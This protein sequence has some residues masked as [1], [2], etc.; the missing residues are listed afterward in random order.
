MKRCTKCGEEKPKSEFYKQKTHKDGLRSQ[1]KKCV[2]KHGKQYRKKDG[3][4]ENRRKYTL[5][6]NHKLTPEQYN[7]LFEKQRGLCSICG[8]TPTRGKKWL[9]VDH[10]HKTG[11]IR[12]LLCG[13]CNRMLG[14][15]KD[16]DQILIL[17][18]LYLRRHQ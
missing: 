9:D 5:K 17:G 18:A 10:N 16:S 15:A 7:E 14:L 6:N 2:N 11:K 12:G 13:D 3:F 8:G 1:C 4:I